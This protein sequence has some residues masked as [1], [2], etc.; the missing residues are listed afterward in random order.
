VTCW[1]LRTLCLTALLFSSAVAGCGTTRIPAS[2]LPAQPIAITYWEPEAARRRAEIEAKASDQQPRQKEGVARLEHIGALLGVYD[3]KQSA[4]LARFPG[5][6]ALVDP[7]TGRVDKIAAATPG[8]RPVAW[9][10]DRKRLL[11][12]SAP[13]AGRNQLLEY[14]VETD[15]VSRLT[16]GDAAALAADYGPDRSLVYAEVK[17]EGRRYRMKLF[18][19][20]AYGASPQLLSETIETDG[21]SW[22][23]SGDVL[24]WVRRDSRGSRATQT[25]VAREPV[26]GS[27]D[28]DLAPGRDPVFT[29][30]GEWVVYSGPVGDGWRLRRMR[31]DG[32]GRTRVGQGARDQIQPAVS[33]DGEFI[34]YIGKDETDIG[35][36][37]VR[38]MDGSGDLRLIT[39]GGASSPAW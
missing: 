26:A 24:L 34:A 10:P 21:L 35:R 7:R 17:R 23:P 32:S 2:E 14:D 28:R 27:Q 19:T 29:A 3:P 37:H 11:F 8:S 22:S 15:L 36:L 6:L 1:L 13:E 4:S 38:R 33:P 30:D 18:V 39:S 9:S 25:V 12:L 20:G 16:P 5:H 31:P